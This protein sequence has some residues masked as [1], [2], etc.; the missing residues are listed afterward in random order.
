MEVKQT[1]D[2]ILINGKSI[3]NNKYTKTRERIYRVRGKKDISDKDIIEALVDEIDYYRNK[4][5]L[6]TEKIDNTSQTIE[7]ERNIF[8]CGIDGGCKD[9][10]VTTYYDRNGNLIKEEICYLDDKL[11]AIYKA[12]I[13]EYE[14]GRTDILFECDKDNNK[15]C[16]KESCMKN[17]YC[18]HTLNKKYAKNYKYEI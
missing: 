17:N 2:D 12:E 14:S 10:Q 9:Y 16:S 4:I 6:L 8:N 3:L 5:Q 15:E 13:F 18:N 7:C 11:K 1:V